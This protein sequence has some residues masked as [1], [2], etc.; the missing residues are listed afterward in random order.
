MLRARWM[1]LVLEKLVVPNQKKYP[2][3]HQK[4]RRVPTI[5]ECYSDDV[6][7]YFEANCQF[8]RDK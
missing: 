3:Y 5:D 7:C 6:T 4:Y 2:W 1:I 8:Q